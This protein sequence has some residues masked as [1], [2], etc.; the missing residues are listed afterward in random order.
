MKPWGLHGLKIGHPGMTK[1]PR[2]TGS[3]VTALSCS[4]E[5]L[6]IA[7]NPNQRTLAYLGG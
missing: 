3:P 5:S 7:L 2:E 4:L 6:V 1:A